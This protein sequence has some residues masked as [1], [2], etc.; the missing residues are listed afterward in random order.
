[1]RIFLTCCPPS[2][3]LARI[4]HLSKFH[5]PSRITLFLSLESSNSAMIS[6]AP[7]SW[8]CSGFVV[9]QTFFIV[10]MKASLLKYLRDWSLTNKQFLPLFRTFVTE[11]GSTISLPVRSISAEYIACQHYPLRRR[12]LVASNSLRGLK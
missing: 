7:I 5:G 3:S 12:P 11:L 6:P 8:N 10:A 4:R 1:M 9:F 2:N